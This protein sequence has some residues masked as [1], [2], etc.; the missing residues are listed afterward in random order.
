MSELTK[1]AFGGS[2]DELVG[3]LPLAE[4][5]R[6]HADSLVRSGRSPLC[7]ALMT[8][9]AADIEAGGVVAKLFAEVPVPPGAA[10]ALRLL[11]ALHYLVLS[12]RAPGL[13]AY[14]PSAGGMH[15]SEHVW[16]VARATLEEHCALVSE[17]VQRGVQTND[18]GRA[19]A[20]YPALLWLTERYRLPIRLLEL[21]ASAGLNL[22]AERFCYIVAGVPLGAP[23]SAVRFTE[24]WTVAPEL[25]LAR[26]ARALRIV[27]RAGCDLAPLDV[28]DPE[29]RLTLLSYIWPDEPQ[30][31]AR[32]R[33]ALDIAALDPPQITAQ[34]AA[35]WLAHA[36][37]QR[38]TGELTV[39]WHSLFRQYVPEH[40]R[41]EL[42]LTFRQAAEQHPADSP[43]VWLSMEPGSSDLPCIELRLQT[44]DGEQRCLA[45]C[46]DHGPPVCWQ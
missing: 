21:G 34:S 44:H 41:R 43:V 32:L 40:E 19:T 12:D 36:L 14:Y 46:G 10:P 1:V 20:L 23:S 7:V 28:R 6:F 35:C 11:G 38:Q 30:R 31:L 42:D 24:P 39:V 22:F 9:A 18:P 45:T 26:A 17:R 15:D 13:A 4:R 2:G 29:D 8:G 3:H 27:E 37:A 33:A 16:P 5:I 25:D